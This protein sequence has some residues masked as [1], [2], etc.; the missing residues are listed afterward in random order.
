M[1]A[2]AGR[3][4]YVMIGGFLGAGKTTAVAA[5]AR[6]L[7]SRGLRCGL[8]A[9]DQSTGLV[10]TKLLRSRGYAVEEIAG[11]CF[12]CRFDS[13]SEAA[14][15][16]TAE[17][18]PDVFVAEPVGS[19]TDLVA[20]VSY[21]LRR[22]Y[23]DRF[24]VAPLSV[25]VDPLRAARIL[26]LERGPSFSRKVVYVYLKQLEEADLILVNKCDR[27]DELRRERLRGALR[28]R[29]PRAEVLAC[30]AREGQGLEAWFE[31]VLSAEFPERSTMELDYDTYAEGEALLGWLN[32]T[33]RLRA[34]GSVDGNRLLLE[35]AE[36]IGR[37]LAGAG[38]EVA[39]LKMTLDSPDAGGLSVVSV[40]AG[41]EEP[42][43]RESLLGELHEGGLIVNLRAE[44]DPELLERWTRESL[45]AI[46]GARPGLAVE[47]EHSEHFRPARPVPTHR[48]SGGVP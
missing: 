9:N 6:H 20:T 31:R 2:Q 21:P 35:L 39:H 32:C 15:R 12:C 14:A 48:V 1:S 8:I 28:E 33:V 40:V 11:G 23:G 45:E 5:L 36:G 38:R 7:G 37:R 34:A 25:M 4:R 43:L 17:T 29:F 46:A 3:A 18:R 10:D 42:D 41:G 19:C 47:L 24:Q 13:L 22:I 44:A 26:G 27:I 16:L 30:S